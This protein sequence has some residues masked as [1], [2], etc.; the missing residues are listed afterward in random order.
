VTKQNTSKYGT[1]R[2]THKGYVV[3][4]VGIGYR[5]W[6]DFVTAEWMQPHVDT[7]AQARAMI[8][9]EIGGAS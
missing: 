6:M 8:A 1:Q 9:F 7:Q 5:I 3:E 4:Q 2:W